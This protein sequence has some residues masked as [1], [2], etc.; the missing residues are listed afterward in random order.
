MKKSNQVKILKSYG[1]KR[2]PKLEFERVNK[3][4]ELQK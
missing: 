3:I 2:I 1:V 4:L